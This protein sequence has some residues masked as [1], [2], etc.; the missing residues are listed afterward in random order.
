M[1]LSL[2]A[3]SP[4]GVPAGATAHGGVLEWAVR[5][6]EAPAFRANGRTVTYRRLVGRAQA[7]R[8]TLL[9]RGM[10]PGAVVHA[11]RHPATAVAL[12]GVLRSGAAFAVLAADRPA[13]ETALRAAELAPRAWLAAAPGRR[14]DGFADGPALDVGAVLAGALPDDA[15]TGSGTGTTPGP[16]EPAYVAFTSGTTGRPRRIIGTHA[17]LI[18]FLDWY[19]REFGLTPADRFSVLS[20]LGH[21]P[22]LRDVLAPL[23]VGAAAVFPDADVHDAEALADELRSREV[24]VTHLT[25]ALADS[26]AAVA[27]PGWPQLRLAGFGGDVLTWRTVQEWTA[28]APGADLL[29]L[30]GATETPQAVSVHLARAAGSPA[31]PG[32]GRVPLG[33]GI[34]G[35]Q[36]LVLNGERQTG[37]GELGEVVVRT[38]HLAR[39]AHERPETTDRPEG[40]ERRTGF[41][42]SPFAKGGP[43]AVCR[44]GDRARLRPDGLLDHVGRADQQVKVRGFRVEPAEIET[45]L[46]ALPSVRAAAMLAVPEPGAGHRMAGY[47]ATGGERP[48]LAAVRRSLAARLADHKVPGSF[49]VVD[50]FP[51]TANGMPDRAGLASLGPEE[52][53]VAA[54]VPPAAG[55]ETE[56]A[57]IW[58]EVLGRERIGAT[59]DFFALGG[60][61]LLLS[62][63]LVRVRRELGTELTLRDLFEH[64]TVAQLA[65]LVG[66]TAGTAL[67]AD[68]VA[69]ATHALPVPRS[70]VP[71]PGP[72]SWT[73]ES[74]WFEEQLRPG[75]AAY[76]MPVLLRISGPLDTGVLQRAVDSVVARHAVLRSRFSLVDGAPVQTTAPGARVVV[77]EAD[78]SAVSEASAL[79][80]AMQETKRPF[81]LA[82]GPLLRVAVLR[83][84]GDTALL[85]LT[86][87]HIV[88]DGWSFGL[89]LDALGEAYRAD[90]GEPTPSERPDGLQVADVARWERGEL[91]GR[92]LDELLSWWG[93]YLG[94][95]PALLQLPTGRPRPPVQAH[96]G[97]R[98]RFAID[99]ATAEGLR[100]L[101]REAGATLF[102]TLLS[103][104]GVVLSRYTDQEQLLVGTPVA[105]RSR[106]EFEDLVGCFVNTVPVRVDLRG[107]PV[108]TELLGRVRD[109]ALA[110]FEHQQVPF[111]K[112]VGAHVPERDLSR[113]PLVQVLFA[114]QNVRLGSFDAPELSSELVEA[115]AANSQFDLNL[116]MLDDGRE[117]LGWL[118]YDSDLFDEATVQ[119]PVEHLSNVTAAVVAQ[120]QASV[121]TVELLG[122]A[123][124]ERLLTTWNDTAESWSPEPTLTSLF[125]EQ[126]RRTPGAV[127]V[128]F[129]GRQ[130][131]YAELHRRADRLARRLRGLGVGPDVVVGV[132]LERSLELMIGLLA[133]LKAGGVYLPLDPGYPAE[134]LEFTLADSGAAVLL[135]GPG[136]GGVVAEG[137]TVLT[138]GPGDAADDT[139]A[140]AQHDAPADALRD[141]PGG[142]VPARV[143]GAERVRAEGGTV[144]RI[145]EIIDGSRAAAAATVVTLRSTGTK[146]PL[147]FVHPLGGSVSCYSNLVEVLDPDQ[148][149][150]AVQAPEYAG[151]ETPRPESIE[152]I[153]ALYL[154]E[155][156][157]VQPEGPYHLGGWCMGGMISYGMAR[158]L[159]AGGMEVATLTIVSASVD[160]PVPP[161][162]AI[163]EAAAIIGAFGHRLP[164]TEEELEQLDDEARIRHVLQLTRGTDDER[165]DTSI[166]LDL[167]RLVRLYQ[168]HARALLT[169]RDTPREP[170]RGDALLIRAETEL[171]TGWD[172]G[173]RERVDGTLLI[174]EPPGTHFTMLEQPN[175]KEVASRIEAAATGE[176]Q[177]SPVR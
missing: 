43:D 142:G 21:D 11:S 108:F 158:Q 150:Y 176:P 49:V 137:V 80:S 36:L 8:T 170:F 138:L 120:R 81:D 47:L 103:A 32:R 140:G 129:S 23:W 19:A 104:F 85:V 18:H 154:S 13:E 68:T 132:R 135:T 126:S 59:D 116:R 66:T 98:H 172:F 53:A 34:D 174:D 115:T 145:A 164:T 107:E 119:R 37:I 165:A 72:L 48:D 161:R 75:G 118:D 60:H 156:R 122:S 177:G 149:F 84:G 33:S 168:R 88:F 83:S 56:L 70:T 38:P 57:S 99:A 79:E 90:A 71:G 153:A 31:P 171:F 65:Q 40:R 35:V 136:S 55:V 112:L 69:A 146:P 28:L 10:Q 128:R 20:G 130:L 96:R 110:A 2:S 139:G 86:V 26:L 100:T 133:V 25:P 16:D 7:V 6:P 124:R 1:S 117:I 113:N 95:T 45:A 109:S 148:P 29:N 17:P 114:L 111:S 61:S 64:P 30:H 41:A 144:E 127:A 91:A 73:Q 44:T 123:E 5:T 62:Q 169:Y 9:S 46:L 166:A 121:A 3:G 78:L 22:F 89:L 4:V 131:D 175:V 105:N 54:D 125:E 14:P 92:R 102:M 82:E 155:L 51:L 12:L 67:A 152:E 134:R 162:Y 93:E 52:S 173:W 141:V 101:G 163:S 151:P 159:Q 50:T 77:R 27:G 106:P 87:Y 24:T 74:L 58:A 147:F 39:Y 160:D 157:T 167:R 42:E 76:N 97:A 94:D 63:V 15:G 143:H